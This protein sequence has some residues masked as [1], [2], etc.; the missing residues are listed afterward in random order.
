M[1]FVFVVTILLFSVPTSEQRHTERKS[2]QEEQRYP[3]T[4][5]TRCLRFTIRDAKG[6]NTCGGSIFPRLP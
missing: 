6:N 2:A 3:V 5:V 1:L 4:L